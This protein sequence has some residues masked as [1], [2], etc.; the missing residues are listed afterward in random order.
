MKSKYRHFKGLPLLVAALGTQIGT[1]LGKTS[2]AVLTYASLGM[3]IGAMIGLIL[4][5]ILTNENSEATSK[6]S[7]SEGRFFSADQMTPLKSRLV[8]TTGGRHQRD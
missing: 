1:Y 3:F 8:T 2:D 4:A 7:T 5:I 6:G